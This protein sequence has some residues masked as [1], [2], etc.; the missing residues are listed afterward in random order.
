[1]HGSRAVTRRCAK[2]W[3]LLPTSGKM[4][5]YIL[6]PL[7]ASAPCGEEKRMLLQQPGSSL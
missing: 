3:A 2:Y 4:P 6:I 1:M 5:E 7:H